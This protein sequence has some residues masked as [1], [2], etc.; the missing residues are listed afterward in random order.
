MK[1]PKCVITAKL[2]SNRASDLY[3]FFVKA[4]SKGIFELIPFQGATKMLNG[5]ASV[6]DYKSDIC[7]GAEVESW[8]L[9][10]D[11]ATTQAFVLSHEELASIVQG[12]TPETARIA[13]LQRVICKSHYGDLLG[14]V[15]MNALAKIKSNQDIMRV[16]TSVLQSANSEKV[17]VHLAA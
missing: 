2:S 1:Q 16:F 5:A 6:T 10:F 8:D 14:H 13:C 12:N 11:S 4:N 17:L 3:A 9:S 15:P 7:N